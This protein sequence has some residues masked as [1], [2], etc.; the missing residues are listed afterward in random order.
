MVDDH[1]TDFT[2]P[3]LLLAAAFSGLDLGFAGF[4]RIWYWSFVGLDHWFWVKGLIWFFMDLDQSFKEESESNLVLR[5]LDFCTTSFK[6]FG[7][8][9]FLLELGFCRLLIQRWQQ[10]KRKRNLFD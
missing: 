2:F 9:G 8:S 1:W 4:H 5:T 3:G 10:R 7:F 6:G